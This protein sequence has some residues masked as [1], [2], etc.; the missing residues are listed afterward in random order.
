M[1]RTFL[2]RLQSHNLPIQ[3]GRLRQVRIHHPCC[4]HPGLRTVAQWADE[5]INAKDKTT[6]TGEAKELEQEIELRKE[7]LHRCAYLTLSPLVLSL[8]YTDHELVVAPP[9]LQLAAE[10]YHK[11]IS[12]KKQS[13][14]LDDPDKF[15]PREAFGI[16][17][18]RH[19]EDFAEDSLFGNHGIIR[20][21]CL[22]FWLNDGVRQDRCL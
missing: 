17:M 2:L 19:G 20:P 7:G 6:L 21:V 10:Q 16:T 11:S 4:P 15:L 3:L 8:T 5:V 18:V 13:H 22:H 14:A 1:S 9:R 12:K